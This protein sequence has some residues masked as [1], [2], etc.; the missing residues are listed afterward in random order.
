[1]SDLYDGDSEELWRDSPDP[2]TDDEFEAEIARF[3]Q[4]IDAGNKGVIL[5]AIAYC[6]EKRRPIHRHIAYNFLNSYCDIRWHKYR[7]WDDVFGRPIPKGHQLIALRRHEALRMAVAVS[8]ETRVERGE[9]I[10][11]IMFD[12]IAEE[13]RNDPVVARKLGAD[14]KGL[15]IGGTLISEVYDECKKEVFKGWRKRWGAD[16]PHKKKDFREV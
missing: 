5:D 10:D 2:V 3:R 7:S 11:K 12:A 9:P 4:Q 15:R 14:K 6:I 8:V 1:V 13:L 16:W